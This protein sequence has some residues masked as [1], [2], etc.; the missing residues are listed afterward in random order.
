M[1]EVLDVSI[2]RRESLTVKF[3]DGFVA[4]LPLGVVRRQCPCAGC[5]GEREQGRASWASR[6]DGYGLHVESAQFV[7][8]WG[9]AI[10]W[11]DGHDTGIYSWDLLR[12]MELDQ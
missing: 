10:R 8:A 6:P 1:A 9:L 5:R 3:E 11:D 12:Q 7:G 2:D 4:H